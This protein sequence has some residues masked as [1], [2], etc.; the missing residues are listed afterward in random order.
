MREPSLRRLQQQVSSRE[1]A[2][3]NAFLDHEP[4]GEERMDV[5]FALLCR[6]VANAHFK[7]DRGGFRLEDFL[8]RDYMALY[9]Q[10]VNGRQKSAQEAER[11]LERRRLAMTIR[12]MLSGSTTVRKG[13]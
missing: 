10:A 11:Q 7:S 13:A 5:R 1:F 12:A 2:R 9:E 4:Q 6:L 3:W 8:A